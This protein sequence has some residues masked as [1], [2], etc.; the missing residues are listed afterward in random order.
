MIPGRYKCD[1]F[2]YS[3]LVEVSPLNWIT[4]WDIVLSLSPSFVDRVSRQNWVT[5]VSFRHFLS[6]FERVSSRRSSRLELPCAHLNF[7]EE[8]IFLLT[9]EWAT[10]YSNYVRLHFNTDFYLSQRSNKQSIHKFNENQSCA[11]VI[12]EN[13]QAKRCFFIGFHFFILEAFERKGVPL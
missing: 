5:W 4:V 11:W 1:T 2:W 13:I 12:L 7:C 10:E 3:A 8:D 9:W 6:F